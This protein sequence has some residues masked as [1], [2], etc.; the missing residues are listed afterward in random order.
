MNVYFD[1]EFIDRG[2][3]V[4]LLSI[5]V[6]KDNGDEY[7]AVIS[8]V[9][10][11]KACPWVQK[12]V[13][14]HLHAGPHKTRDE[15]ATEIADFIGSG[16]QVRWWGWFPAYDWVLLCGLYGGLMSIP[17]NWAQLPFCLRQETALHSNIEIPKHQKTAHNALDDAHWHRSIHKAMQ[18]T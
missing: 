6:V 16:D 17:S 15:V 9:D 13:I 1:T 4:D 5:G 8:G 14:P 3:A 2:Y 18:H 11:K 12:N 7:Y 10:Y